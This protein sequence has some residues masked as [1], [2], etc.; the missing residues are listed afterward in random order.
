[1]LNW[2]FFSDFPY[3]TGFINP[4]TPSTVMTPPPQRTDPYLESRLHS[5]ELACAGL[6]ELL[7]QKNGYTDDEL[8]DLIKQLDQK[9]GA[10]A[11]TTGP[12][13]CPKC[14]HQMLTHNH[15]KC[16]WCGANL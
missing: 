4:Y 14:G 6:W 11:G 8:V 2:L 13:V 9:R 3:G 7:K 15:S 16:L 5:L 1:M 10:H 12:T